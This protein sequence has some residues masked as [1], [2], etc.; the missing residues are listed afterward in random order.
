MVDTKKRGDTI[1]DALMAQIRAVSGAT[2][3]TLL[4]QIWVNDL[5]WTLRN[6]LPHGQLDGM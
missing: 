2:E 3:E 1:F 4:S 6:P 5:G